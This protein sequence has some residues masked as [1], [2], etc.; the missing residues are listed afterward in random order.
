MTTKTVPGAPSPSEPQEKQ[1]AQLERGDWIWLVDEDG[2]DRGNCEVLHVETYSDQI[3]RVTDL[4][5]RAAGQ[6]KPGV[7]VIGADFTVELLP[8]DRVEALREV[9]ARSQKI[10]KLRGFADFLER[11]PEVPVKQL[12]YDLIHL[13]GAEGLATVRALAAKHGTKVQAHLDDR[14]ETTIPAGGFDLGVIAWHKDGRPAEPKPE[15]TCDEPVDETGLGHSRE[16]APEDAPPATGRRIKPHLEDGTCIQVR[17]WKGE[18]PGTCGVE[19]ACGVTFDGFD[20]LAEAQAILAR[21]VCEPVPAAGELVHFDNPDG[22]SACGLAATTPHKASAT[23]AEVDCK[24]CSDEA[25]F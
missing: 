13:Y 10:T 15:A 11:N 1:V 17:G 3:G 18:D 14:T 8:E 2:E 4:H 23:W 12:G 20:T 19:A 22:V 6:A 7:A 25:P 9:S 24:T 21:H 5:Y 16:V